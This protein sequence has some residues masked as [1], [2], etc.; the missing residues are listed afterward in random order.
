VTTMCA[1]GDTVE[2]QSVEGGHFASVEGSTAW[3]NITTWIA[4]RFAGTEAVTT[5]AP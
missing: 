3:P 4:D 2:L 1:I 5:C